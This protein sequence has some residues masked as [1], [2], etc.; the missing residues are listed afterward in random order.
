MKPL[1]R[2]ASVL[3]ALGATFSA[4]AVLT[5]YT[6]RAAFVAATA[7]F[8]ASTTETFDTDRALALGDNLY[9]GVDYRLTGATEG[10]NAISNGALQGDEY[11]QSSLDLVFGSAIQAFGADF[12]EANTSSGLFFTINGETVDLA[13]VLAD[14]GTGF[15]G[16]VSSS[17][18]TAVDVNGGANPN[19]I[20]ALDNLTSVQAVPEPASLAAL[21][22]G[23]VGLLRRR[24]RA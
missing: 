13:S 23:A 10:A 18:F 24:K 12:T 4:H 16:V 17:A 20:Y 14:P 19:E 8:G 9:N 6:S 7:G 15:F 21:G 5:V 3:A 22:L 11:F 1:L 2:S